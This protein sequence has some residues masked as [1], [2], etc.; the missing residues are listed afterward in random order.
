MA[1]KSATTKAKTT[2]AVRGTVEILPLKDVKPN[3]WNPNRMTEEMMASLQHGL[4]HDGW[5]ASQALLVWGTDA[6]GETRNVIIDGEHRYRGALAIGLTEGP[7]VRLDGLSEA[8]AKALTVKL[9]QKRGEWD[10]KAL[11][12]LLQSIQF[13][14]DGANLALEFG[15]AEDEMMKLLASAPEPLE[16]LLPATPPTREPTSSPATSGGV[17]PA[18]P[19]PTSAVRM[20]QLFLDDETHPAFLAHVQALAK[21]WDKK[22]VTEVVLEAVKIVAEEAAASPADAA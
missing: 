15:F 20:V 10:E 11:S 5:L 2:N 16:G 18:P 4:R 22:N 21:L 1:K 7:M 14:V 6:D 19:P 8:E 17:E 3:P 9:N 12:D 13:D